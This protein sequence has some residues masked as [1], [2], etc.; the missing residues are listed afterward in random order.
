[1]RQKS[2]AIASFAVDHKIARRW[3]YSSALIAVDIVDITQASLLRRLRRQDAC[4]KIYYL[5]TAPQNGK[6]KR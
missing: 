4:H 5:K 6:A 1:M 3:E 2:N